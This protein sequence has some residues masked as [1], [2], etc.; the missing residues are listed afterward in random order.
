MNS[1]RPRNLISNLVQGIV[2]LVGA[3]GVALTVWLWGKRRFE[4]SDQDT[5]QIN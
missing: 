5:K 4:H 1:N 2:F 3:V